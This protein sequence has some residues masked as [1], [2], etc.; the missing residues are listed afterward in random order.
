MFQTGWAKVPPEI[1][2]ET[3][4]SEHF[5]IHFPPAYRRFAAYLTNYLE[6]AHIVLSRDLQWKVTDPIEVVVRGDTDVPNGFSQAFPFNRLVVHAVPFSPV[7]FIGEYD[8]WIRTLAYHE[9]THS[10]ANDTT[11]GFFSTARTVFGSAA[12]MNPLQPLWL[13]EGLAVYE[14]TL[15]SIYGR[16]RSAFVDMVVRA[17]ARDSLLNSTDRELGLTIDRL[18]DG[19][20][21]WPGGNTA[22]IY[23]YVMAEMAA[24]AGGLGAPGR[25][26][27]RSGGTFPFTINSVANRELGQDYYALWDRAVD[28]M[29]AAVA[30]DLKKVRAAPV[31]GIRGLTPRGRQAGRMSSGPVASRDGSLIYFVRDS[32]SQGAGI[33]VLDRKTGEVSRISDWRYG[34]GSRLTLCG[35]GRWLTYSRYEPHEEFYRYSDV[36]LWDLGRDREIQVTTGGRAIDPDCS[37]GFSWGRKGRASGFLAWVRNL[38]DGN[39]G[40]VVWDGTGE[41]VLYRGERF[42]RLSQPVWGRGPFADWIVFTFKVNGGNER[43][44]AVNARTSEVRPLTRHAAPSLRVSETTPSWTRSGDL[45]F[46]SAVGGIF[47]IYRLDRDRLKTVLGERPITG[48]AT[49]VRLTHLETGAFF[50]IEGGRS[51]GLLAMHYGAAGFDVAELEIAPRS[52]PPVFL[53]PL[54]L[55]L[56][57]LEADAVAAMRAVEPTKGEIAV[58]WPSPKEEHSEALSER[59]SLFPSLWPKYWLPFVEK[60]PDGWILGAATG[61][62]DALEQHVYAAAAAWDSRAD[63]PLY[64]LNYAYDGLYPT[65]RISRRQD[66]KYL[67]LFAR[68][69]AVSTTGAGMHFS[70]GD[71]AVDFG[72]TIAESSFFGR[73][74]ASGGA[75]GHLGHRTLRGYPNSIDVGGETGHAADVSLAG[76]FV[77]QNRFASVE[78]RVEQRIPSV[79][80]QHF[81]RFVAQGARSS[82]HDLSSL[83]FVGGGE[84]VVVAAQPFL[85]RGY[86]PGAIYGRT[87]ATAS[88]EYWLPIRDLFRGRGILPAFYERSKLRLIADVGSAEFV[89]TEESRLRHWPVGV[90]IHLLQ[91]VKVLYRLPFTVALGFDWG[92]NDRFRGETQVVFGIYARY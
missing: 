45:L 73:Q 67:G 43:L 92:L 17:A 74:S 88:A 19:A 2:W 20:P 89:G 83:Y 86:A 68:S 49:P 81:F 57:P 69:N 58:D 64:E 82:N 39:Q 13:S 31:T 65:L 50:P 79:F 37:P 21:V 76:Y 27:S 78:A 71:W 42:E 3:V 24:E 90:G 48:V 4:Q 18:N 40:L 87:L 54:H 15:R 9:L 12:K 66:N 23:G 61:G 28:R 62:L 25:V 77:G 35:G 46:S 32:Y 6:E 80:D 34:G 55:K 30:S 11:M 22:Y 85:L 91:D 51:G 10:I 47:N 72:V 56:R 44:M 26:S 7:G 8:N 53:Q 63:F 14:E 1:D 75:M 52:D 5:R 84:G 70:L 16:G 29:K 41:R 38:G 36:F 33:S 60:V 59:Y